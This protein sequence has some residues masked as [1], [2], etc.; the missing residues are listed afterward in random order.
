MLKAILHWLGQWTS[1][2]VVATRYTDLL[3]RY[4]TLAEKN[5]T[6]QATAS[7]YARRKT[8]SEMLA[9]HKTTGAFMARQKTRS[10]INARF[11]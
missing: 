4:D 3:A 5:A 7:K 2:E 8:S 11:D 6:Y 9:T 10:D 1:E